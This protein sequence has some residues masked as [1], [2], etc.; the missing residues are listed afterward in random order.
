MSGV[1]EIEA[2]VGEDQAPPGLAHLEYAGRDFVTRFLGRC[3]T[4]VREACYRL[5][6]PLSRSWRVR[7][8]SSSARFW[9]RA[10]ALPITEIKIGI[11][12]MMMMTRPMPAA[13]AILKAKD[14]LL[15]P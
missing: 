7:S 8:S 4:P 14:L 3:A 11:A 2:A 13:T 10:P 12:M 9:L 1:Q 5:C 6:S 15:Q